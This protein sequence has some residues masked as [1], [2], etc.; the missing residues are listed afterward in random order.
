MVNDS[1]GDALTKQYSNYPSFTLGAV[2]VSPISLVNAYATIAARGIRCEPT[3]SSRS[4]PPTAA[5]SSPRCELPA[6]ARRGHSRT[7]S[8]IFQGPHRSGTAT[9]SRIPGYTVAGK[10]GTVPFNKAAWLWAS[11]ATL[12]A[13]P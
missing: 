11:P 10:T 3:P 1:K 6:R 4:R 8:K 5:R 2:E 12:W 13:A 9:Q 7:L